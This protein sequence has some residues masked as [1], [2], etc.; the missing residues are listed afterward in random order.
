MDYSSARPNRLESWELDVAAQV[1]YLFLASRPFFGSPTVSPE[2]LV[3][4]C[5][6][7]WLRQR[8]R[9]RLNRGASLQTYMRRVLERFL[10]DLERKS[11]AQKRG[12]GTQPLS[13]DFT[14]PEEDEDA[15][16]ADLIADADSAVQPEERLLH[17]E[18]SQRIR[19]AVLRLSQ[20]Q[21]LLAA[22]LAE[23]KSIS[24]MSQ[25][26]GVHRDTLYA[27]LR[28]IKAIFQDDGLAEFLT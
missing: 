10:L 1:V 27:D 14:A 11:K 26:L 8:H 3:Q 28:R 19:R 17:R 6:L 13:L 7:H 9:Y 21:Q 16:L 15:N 25:L 20:R 24:E 22:G 4:D 2:D 23:G 5:L 18:R 12:S